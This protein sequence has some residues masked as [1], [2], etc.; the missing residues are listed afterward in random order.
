M[1]A[2]VRYN[3][4]M[5]NIDL[6]LCWGAVHRRIGKG[7]IIFY[8]GDRGR[9]YYQIV[10]GKV[11]MV[12][13]NE[14]GKEFIQ[15]IYVDGETFGELPLFDGN[16]YLACAVAEEDTLLIRLGKESFI[17]ILKD[18]F[19]LHFAFTRLMAGR[20]R[21]KSVLL[22]ELSCYGPEHRIVTLIR[23][24]KRTSKLPWEAKYKVDL[25]RQQIADMTGLRVETVIR[26]IRSLYVK[27]DLLLKN[28]KVYV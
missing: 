7:Q 15:G 13:C 14:E 25:T 6:L 28:G 8:Q 2:I 18:D 3:L 12:S 20:S 10:T 16:T 21:F 26:A 9:Y 19:T 5:I 24:F 23:Q 4:A 17:H 1:S 22:K 27:G 11:K